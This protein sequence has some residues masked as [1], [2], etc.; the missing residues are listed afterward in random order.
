M[1]LLLR[2]RSCSGLLAVI[3]L[4][5]LP[6]PGEPI[7]VRFMEGS[8]HGFLVIHSLEGKVIASGDVTQSVHGNRMVNHLVFR[9]KDGSVDDETAVFSQRGTF[10]LISDHHIQRGPSFPQPTNVQINASSGQVTVR[11]QENGKE[12]TETEHLNL[13]PDLAN[14]MILDLL[15]NI[16]ANAK[17]TKLSYV[18]ATPKPRI[19]QLSITPQ[20]QEMFSVAGAHHKA[21]RFTVKVEIGGITGMFASL[22]GKQ[23]ADINFWVVGGEAPAFVKA[24]GPMFLGGPT[25]STEMSSPVWRH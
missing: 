14:G 3:L 18:A 16:P 13:P 20:G 6:A 24:E 1:N 9:F 22:V 23:P 7:A 8:L 21:I 17:E 11:Y 4:Q 2:P 19:V 5:P 15:K 10:R 25:W 12:K